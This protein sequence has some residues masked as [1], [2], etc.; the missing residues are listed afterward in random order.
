[1]QPLARPGHEQAGAVLDAPAGGARAVGPAIDHD[2]LLG[3]ELQG[4]LLGNL[5]V[6]ARVE[7]QVGRP[8][9]VLLPAVAE[10]DD[11]ELARVGD[12]VV[13]PLERLAPPQHATRPDE[14]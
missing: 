8:R 12:E 6:N 7:P 10:A 1:M 4:V 13:H 2:G 14:D 5:V 9:Q 3:G 11:Q